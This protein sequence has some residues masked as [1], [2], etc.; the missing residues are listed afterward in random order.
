MKKIDF[1]IHTKKTVSDENIDFS[2]SLDVL[3]KYIETNDL[4]GIA[5]TNHN[6][7]DLDQFIE[8]NKNISINCFPGIEVNLVNGHILLIAPEEYIEQLSFCSERLSSYIKDKNDFINLDDFIKIFGEKFLK[9]SLLIPHYDKKPKIDQGT[10]NKLDAIS[11]IKWGEVNSHKKF[12]YNKKDEMK[13]TPLIFS[14][15]RINDTLNHLEVNKHTYI[16]TNTLT[17]SS[18]KRALMNKSNVSSNIDETRGIIHMPNGLTISTGLNVV[19]GARAS[20]KT[21]LLE[22]LINDYHIDAKYIKQFELVSDNEESN[23]HSRLQK[24]YSQETKEYLKPLEDIV[25]N[26]KE[27]DIKQSLSNLSSYITSLLSY[28]EYKNKMDIYSKA[29]LFNEKE[30]KLPDTKNLKNAISNVESLINNQKYNYIINQVLGVNKLK[31]LSVALHTELRKLKKE[32]SL[33]QLTNNITEIIQKKLTTKSSTPSVKRTNL[34]NIA[35]DIQRVKRFNTLV[36]GMK[37]EKNIKTI[38]L[39]NFYKKSIRKPFKGAQEIK[40]LAKSRDKFSEAF[41][42]YDDPYAYL[43]AL[44]EIPS[45]NVTDLHK[46]FVKIDHSIVNYSG[47][48]ISGGQRTEFIFLQKI[49]NALDYDYLIIDEP[50][51]SFDNIFLKESI[52]QYIQDVS[53]KI[54]VIMTTHNSTLGTSI[55]PDYLIY[56]KKN[57]ENDFDVFYGYP[58][59]EFLKNKNNITVSNKQ[60]QLDYFEAGEKTYYERNKFYE[61]FN[62]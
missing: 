23:F 46:F 12:S 57:N 20:G 24:S 43:C 61:T 62:N 41:N 42:K 47:Q 3:K 26:I 14:D 60:V 35:K 2:F 16:N 59:D 52:N 55:N 51:G 30:L 40:S 7:F 29:K 54:T 50:E 19:V 27:I 32:A 21:T 39:Q 49:Q 5:I 44:K 45:I 38:K 6:H 9:D 25:T 28:A 37:K 1:H 33:A 58:N 13:L 34:Y 53:N 31:E 36:N 10:I 22:T 17:I 15:I 48:K 4:D 18:I 8:I 11:S 56:C